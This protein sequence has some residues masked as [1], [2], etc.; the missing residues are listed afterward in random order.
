MDGK[1][2]CDYSTIFSPYKNRDILG[3]M[4]YVGKQCNSI[5]SGLSEIQRNQRL[6]LFAN[7]HVIPGLTDFSVK[8]GQVKQCLN[9]V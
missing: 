2:A 4:I 8:R 5:A 3:S 6:V 9:E 1:I 7:S